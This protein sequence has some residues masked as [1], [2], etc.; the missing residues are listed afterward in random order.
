MTHASALFSPLALRGVTLRN[1]IVVSPMWQYKGVDGFSTDW[2][3]MHLGRF[4]AGG[5]GLVIQEGTSPIQYNNGTAGDL[6]LW[7]DAFIEPLSRITQFISS[8]GSVPGIQLLQTGRKARGKYPWHGRGPLELE[9]DDDWQ[10]WEVVGATDTPHAPG[11]PVPRMLSIPDI[12]DTVAGWAKA[13]TRA[14]AAGYE[15]LELQGGHGYLIHEFLSAVTNTRTDGYGGSFQ[16]RIRFLVEIVEA[17]RRVWPDRKALFV[18]LSVI[19]GEGWNLEDSVNLALTL[20][21]IG[22]DLIDCSSGGMGATAASPLEPGAGIKLEP[23]YQVPL[24][25]A[26]RQRAEIPTMAV[27]LIVNA[28]QADNVITSGGADLVAMGRELLLSPNWPLIAE[29]ELEQQAG[30]SSAPES[31]AYY[32]AGREKS[33]SALSEPIATRA[34]L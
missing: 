22:V 34:L 5:A 17:I 31:T 10:G 15:V 19:D 9:G 6:G 28:Q 21:A 27:G 7:D 14:D 2:H 25:R 1:R 3:L 24:A 13:A 18:R 26:V 23:G 8:Q 11:Y 29:K 20:K 16:N 12:A 32:L 4:A 30:F 33:M